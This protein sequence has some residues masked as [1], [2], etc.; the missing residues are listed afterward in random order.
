[1]PPLVLPLSTCISE[2]TCASK[3]LAG[4]EPVCI[5]SSQAHPSGAVQCEDMRTPPSP[6]CPVLA[7]PDVVLGVGIPPGG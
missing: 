2:D 3:P 6:S 5:P 4:H 1:M 7:F